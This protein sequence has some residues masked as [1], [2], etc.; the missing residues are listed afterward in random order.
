MQDH[1][2]I[3]TPEEELI[4]GPVSAG[5][6]SF[7]RLALQT[8]IQLSLVIFI[9]EIVV[10]FFVLQ[11]PNS[12]STL[13]LSAL[14]AA[15]IAIIVSPVIHILI[16]YLI[17]TNT[18]ITMKSHAQTSSVASPRIPKLSRLAVSSTCKITLLVFAAEFMI[19][20]I[21]F[22]TQAT[23]PI[24]LDPWVDA[25]VLS[26][27]IS[28][29]TFFMIV[30]PLHT[31]IEDTVDRLSST[32]SQLHAQGKE[33]QT[34]I[35][36][37]ED[38]CKAIDQH[39]SVSVTDCK[40][41]IIDCNKKMLELSG[42]SREELLGKNHRIFKSGEHS[43]EFYTTMWNTISSG[44]SWQ[45]VIKNRRKNGSFYW[46]Y[47]TIIPHYDHAG[48]ITKYIAVRNDITKQRDLELRL[49][50]KHIL[51]NETERVVG[52]G[53]WECDVSDYS[54][55]WS[56]ELF[57][58]L[59][60]D[61]KDTLNFNDAA[62]QFCPDH[63]DEIRAAFDRCV[64]DRISWDLDLP[65]TTLKENLIWARLTGEPVIKNDKVTH[66]RG[67]FQNITQQH[68]YQERLQLAN[69]TQAGL[70]QLLEIG[71]SADNEEDLLSR[72]LQVILQVPFIGHQQMAAAFLM[73]DQ[74]GNLIMRAQIGLAA[75][76]LEKCKV[77]TCGTC[78]CGRAAQSGEILF[79]N[80]VDHRHDIHFEGMKPHG[81]YNVP[82]K[83]DDEV[84]GVI[85]LYI[86]HG[87]E[88]SET[89][90]QFLRSAAEVIASA[91]YRLTS[92]RERGLLLDQFAEAKDSAEATSIE[93][94]RKAEELTIASELADAA[95]RA[96]SEFLANMSHEIR[97]PM[98]AILGFTD[99][100]MDPEYRNQ[101]WE[102]AVR[103]I[104]RNGRHLLTIINDILDFSKIES[105]KFTVEQIEMSIIDIVEQ[106]LSLMRVRAQENGLQ[107]IAEYRTVIPE[108]IRSDPTRIQQILMNLI[109]NAIKFT[110]E[111]EVRVVIGMLNKGDTKAIRFDIIDTGIGMTS[112]QIAKLFKPFT[113]ADNST[114][115]KFGG[116]GL[117][118]TISR[119]LAE[120]LNGYIDVSS[121]PGEGSNF[122]LTIHLVMDEDVP[123]IDPATMIRDDGSSRVS[124]SSL[125]KNENNNA[126][127]QF[128][129]ER[130]LLAE[131]GPDNQRLISFVLKRAGL[132]VD[133]AENGRIACEKALSACDEGN[134]Y[135]VILMDVQ[136]PEMDGYT[137]TRT[138]RGQGY[139]HPI[140]AL[141]AHAMES[142][143]LK[144]IEAGCD[145][146]DSKP[147][148]KD[149]LL[150]LIDQILKKRSELNDTMEGLST[151]PH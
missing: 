12:I 111:G 66:I 127:V 94:A 126:T 33:L 71:I 59:E 19:M 11:L 63:A 31:T 16:R 62:L 114:T 135:G 18:S 130:I 76:L 118:L 120:L 84:L 58:I 48:R 1:D 121:K 51:L 98:T 90:I 40:G 149:H 92:D 43:R 119:R 104:Q 10:M 35:M 54:M 77:I 85:A 124:C 49:R 70:N 46:V 22:L 91:L 81:H 6:I 144:C 27:I 129:G 52:V 50:R 101:G 148:K 44:K 133:I 36:T 14:D 146:F 112:E 142:E 68:A 72:S 115:R 13:V 99:L 150:N 139:D 97:T 123:L 82:I 102:D 26:L 41:I 87:T 37:L 105:G 134:P 128:H 100:L 5:H 79:S 32:N 74:T 107:L 103:T 83:I 93:L 88:R 73:D 64:R 25:G 3:A 80:C 42:Y 20:R 39:L 15:L 28:P 95:N 86:D 110:H 113:Q 24:W 9:A 38:Y 122:S 137:A 132:C 89:T 108:S 117:G 145:D 138:L 2:A 29:I 61:E 136:M 56:D 147:I 55:T 75:P 23:I 140:I 69:Q 125:M 78:L 45:G 151:T 131:D 8:T 141:T 4:D 106:V 30:R 47:S 96:K 65:F 34:A 17:Y 67:I 21:L 143:R 60:F 109:G 53:G 57:R 7:G 116:T